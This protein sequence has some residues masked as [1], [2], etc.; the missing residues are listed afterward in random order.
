MVIAIDG[1]AGTGKSTVAR[2]VAERLGFTYLDTGAM[3]RAVALAGGD[4]AEVAAR[5]DIRVGDRVLLDGSDVTEAIRTP[6]VTDDVHALEVDHPVLGDAGCRVNAGLD[7]QVVAQR[8]DGHLDNKLRR[9]VVIGA[10]A[11][12]AGDEEVGLGLRTP[13]RQRARHADVK[14]RAIECRH[15]PLGEPNDGDVVLA[16][17]WAHV[18]EPPVDELDSHVVGE[19]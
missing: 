12:M 7:Q 14:V 9:A 1:P 16:A 4:P 5:A 10:R 19:A 2:A 11:V 6:E 15:D 3:Y 13:E 18:D 8:G 17:L